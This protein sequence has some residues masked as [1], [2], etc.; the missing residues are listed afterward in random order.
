MRAE[1]VVLIWKLFP[2]GWMHVV[3]GSLLLRSP[4][5]VLW[6][7]RGRGLRGVNFVSLFLTQRTR[8]GCYSMFCSDPSRLVTGSV[9]PAAFPDIQL[10]FFTSS[11]SSTMTTMFFSGILSDSLITTM[12]CTRV[13]N[14]VSGSWLLWPWWQLYSYSYWLTETDSSLHTVYECRLLNIQRWSLLAQK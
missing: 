5:A 1:L 3:W 11:T 13:T 10:S 14:W 4:V 9:V 8:M 2:F 6:S 7:G 12:M